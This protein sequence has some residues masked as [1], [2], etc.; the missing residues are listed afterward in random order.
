MYTYIYTYTHIVE[1]YGH[2]TYMYNLHILN[3]KHGK[4]RLHQQCRTTTMGDRRSYVSR[5]AAEQPVHQG[6]D[7][8]PYLTELLS[9]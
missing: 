3:D 9:R 5:G 4:S 1:L 8:L 7:P 2:M 6:S